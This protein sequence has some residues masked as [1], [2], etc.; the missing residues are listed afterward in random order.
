MLIEILYVPGCC[1]HMPTI[2]RVKDI[3]CA[4]RMELPVIEVVVSEEADARALKFPGSPTVRV[5]G[6]DV[7]PSQAAFGF[8]CRLYADGTGLPSKEALRRAI[9]SARHQ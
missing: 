7:E 4:E 6:V 8:A 2:D 3:L 5:D 1:N 9:A